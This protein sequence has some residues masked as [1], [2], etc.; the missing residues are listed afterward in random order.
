MLV[1]RWWCEEGEGQT[2]EGDVV[3]KES[4]EPRELMVSPSLRTPREH[5]SVRKWA[6][7]RQGVHDVRL[8]ASGKS[9]NLGCFVTTV[10]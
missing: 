7:I 3:K 10:S 4:A 1:P 6:T 9:L 2:L 5:L 8:P